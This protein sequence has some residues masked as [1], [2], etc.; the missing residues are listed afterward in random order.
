M[1]DRDEKHALVRWAICLAAG[2]GGFF[3]L[4]ACSHDHHHDDR[5][6]ERDRVVYPPD[7]QVVEVYDETGRRHEGYY[8]RNRDWHGGYYDE[9]RDFHRDQVAWGREHDR[10]RYEAHDRDRDREGDRR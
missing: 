10:A 1:S 9:R 7:A 6:V 4:A 8:D 2:L 5:V 3:G